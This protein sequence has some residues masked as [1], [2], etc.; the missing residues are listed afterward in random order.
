MRATSSEWVSSRIRSNPIL[1][2]SGWTG[3]CPRT[4]KVSS[5]GRVDGDSAASRLLR[6]ETPWSATNSTCCSTEASEESS[7]VWIGRSFADA[8]EIDGVVEVEGDGF[9]GW[10]DGPR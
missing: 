7:G 3:T 4:S 2:P 10:A 6:S 9:G 1:P 5:S 8:P